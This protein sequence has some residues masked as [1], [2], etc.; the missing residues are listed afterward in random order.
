MDVCYTLGSYC[1]CVNVTDSADDLW[2]GVVGVSNAGKKKGR[3]KRVGRKKQTD[4]NRGQ[5]LGTGKL[6]YSK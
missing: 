3:G 4:L 2:K 6:L 5:I 1:V